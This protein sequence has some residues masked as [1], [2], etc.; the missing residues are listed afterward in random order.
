[1][2]CE[3]EEDPRA[4]EAFDAFLTARRYDSLPDDESAR[5]WEALAWTWV[6]EQPLIRFVLDRPP[7]VP[8]ERAGRFIEAEDAAGRVS[9]QADGTRIRE[10]GGF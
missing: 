8:R 5:R 7:A 10:G 6:P 2:A 1:M 9:T 4:R 3:V